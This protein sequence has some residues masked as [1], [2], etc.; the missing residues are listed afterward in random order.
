MGEGFPGMLESS[1]EA[2]C[3]GLIWKTWL[4]LIWDEV[5]RQ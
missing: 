4:L 2:I 5:C 3:E 1:T